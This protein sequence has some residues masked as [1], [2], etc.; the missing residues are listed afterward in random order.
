MRE[1]PEAHGARGTWRAA[2]VVPAWRSE[3]ARSIIKIA[4]VAAELARGPQGDERRGWGV[5]EAG[6]EREREA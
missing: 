4:L 1:H 3:I 6:D 5:G 2:R